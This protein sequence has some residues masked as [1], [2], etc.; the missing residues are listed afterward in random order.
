MPQIRSSTGSKRS[1]GAAAAVLLLALASLALA[2]C[3]GSSSGSGTTSTSATTS[4]A[5]RTPQARRF[6]AFR[7]C[8][9]KNGVSL[10]KFTPGKRP[11]HA[12]GFD[13][14]PGNPRL[15]EGVSS[16]QYEAAIKKCGGAPSDFAG[17][18]RFNSPAV[19]QALAKFAT[20]MRANGENVPKPNTSGNGRPVFSSKGLNVTS[21]KFK[22]AE[23]KCRRDLLGSFRAHP[24][25]AGGAPQAPPA[26]AG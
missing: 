8:M 25:G 23:A 7:E 1:R 3:G 16:A 14:A 6:A 10:P 13:G 12:R 2:A 21:A 5:G 9:K 20:C 22:A 17:G 4:N 24:G 26:S 11:P 18:R 15:P 19:R